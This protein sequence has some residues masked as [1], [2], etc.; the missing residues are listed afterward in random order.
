MAP[1]EGRKWERPLELI[2]Y[3]ADSK[4]GFGI[5]RAAL[6]LLESLGCRPH[7]PKIVRSS[8]VIRPRY[9][10]VGPAPFRLSGSGMGCALLNK[11]VSGHH[12]ESTT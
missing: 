10:V 3:L 5:I 4:G 1:N 12:L 7:N 8:C 11:A 6:S 9:Y 2:L